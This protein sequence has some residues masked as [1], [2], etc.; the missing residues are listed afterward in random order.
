MRTASASGSLRPHWH[1]ERGMHMHS[2][3]DADPERSE[4]RRA[5][6]HRRLTDLRLV[7]TPPA[8]AS[9]RGPTPPDGTN[10][11]HDRPCLTH[12]PAVLLH[13]AEAPLD[14]LTR[15]R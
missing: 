1:I 6:M 7:A 9:G 13:E 2:D 11:D 5:A 3:N 12:P 4:R 8:A 14:G 10:S 15:A